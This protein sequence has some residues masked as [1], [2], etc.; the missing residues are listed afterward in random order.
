ML[1]FCTLECQKKGSI[2]K[3]RTRNK[4][5]GTSSLFRPLIYFLQ[6]TTN[7]KQIRWSIHSTTCLVCIIIQIRSKGELISQDTPLPRF[8]S[9]MPNFKSLLLQIQI[10]PTKYLW[11]PFPQVWRQCWAILGNRPTHLSHMGVGF[12]EPL[13]YYELFA[14][15]Y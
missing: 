8:W 6:N 12:I 11:Y 15:P 2:I 5:Y 14:E 7:G 10:Y 9:L 3:Y 13:G 4:S 1:C